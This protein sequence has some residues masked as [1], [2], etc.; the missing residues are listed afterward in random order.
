[1]VIAQLFTKANLFTI[2]AGFG[3][4]EHRP[5]QWPHVLLVPRGTLKIWIRFVRQMFDPTHETNKQTNKQV[6]WHIG[7]E[8][9]FTIAQLFLI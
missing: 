1:M 5:F 3:E 6:R 9:W 8:I 7:H 2:R 4:C